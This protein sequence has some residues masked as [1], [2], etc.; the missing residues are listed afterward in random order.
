MA[1]LGI[2][3]LLLLLPLVA[4]AQPQTGLDQLSREPGLL[5]AGSV[6]AIVTNHTGRTAQGKAPTRL[7]AL[8]PGSRLPHSLHLSTGSPAPMI[9]ISAIP[10]LPA[11]RSTRSMADGVYR[12]QPCWLVSPPL[13]LISRMLVFVTTPT[14][15]P[16]MPCSKQL[17]TITC[18]YSYLIAP[19]HSAEA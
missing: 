18:D 7:S 11:F 2:S 9:S 12:Q 13:C 15:A 6:V 19:T 8:F 10:G 1:R 4:Q 14:S 17:R 16:C 3:I 5:P